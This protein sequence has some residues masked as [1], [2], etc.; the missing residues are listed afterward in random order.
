MS[1]ICSLSCRILVL[2][3]FERGHSLACTDLFPPPSPQAAQGGGHRTLL[4]GHA[5]LLRHS[6]SGMVS[7]SECPLSPFREEGEDEE[8]GKH[9]KPANV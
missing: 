5:I 9:R 3:C 7:T 1:F 2:L 8:G 6:F 4:Y